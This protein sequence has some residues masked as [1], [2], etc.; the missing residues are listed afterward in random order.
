[1]EIE[2]TIDALGGLGDGIARLHGKPII[3]PKTCGGDR[4]KVQIIRETKD[5]YHGVMTDLIHPGPERQTP[6]CQYF[7][8][9]GG[10]TMQ[11]LVPSAY[12]DFKHRLLHEAIA[13]TG[14]AAP[15]SEVIFLP[16]HTR[17]RVEFKLH[18]TKSNVS[19]AFHALRSH[20]P[21]VVSEC[22]VLHPALQSL[23]GPLSNA[24][25]ALPGVDAIYAVSATIA[26]EGI[27]LVLIAKQ[28]VALL[29][30][31]LELL[32]TVT[33]I[34]RVSTRIGDDAPRVA[35]EASPV[36]MHLGGY[37]VALPPGAFLQATAQGQQLLTEHV[38]RA[39]KPNAASV[40]DLF[41]GIGTYSFSLSRH[42]KTH[43][44][45]GDQT[46]V[47]TITSTVSKEQIKGLTAERRDLFKNPLPASVLKR[48][49]AAVINPPR[50]GAKAQTEQIANSGIPTVVM[51]SC[52]PA[53]FARDA[54]ILRLAGYTLAF[55]QGIDQFLWSQ[56]L[57]IAAVFKKL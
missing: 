20:T 51:I 17:R 37:P 32:C 53:T 11:H 39:I 21:V 50:A 25:S 38:V 34:A 46:M 47:D 7:D 24:L 13:R 4:L 1:M 16:A 56:H 5:C 6:P 9:C 54:A 28:P 3:I 12:S 14:F 30:S 57:E 10:C 33:G 27:D 18:H 22:L 23:I 42:A 49:D 35:H 52:N 43:A 41:C 36:K 45:E 2:V 26:D 19:L 15:Q 48:F 44:V 31:A 8:R 55:I 29:P 40:I